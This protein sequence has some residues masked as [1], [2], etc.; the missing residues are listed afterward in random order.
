MPAPYPVVTAAVLEL[1][2]RLQA[3]PEPDGKYRLNY[4]E[5]EKAL[6]KEAWKKEPAFVA[7]EA[8]KAEQDA[9]KK[10]K[11][12][13]DALEV[14]P[15]IGEAIVP[16]A[17]KAGEADLDGVLSR[18]EKLQVGKEG[19]IKVKRTTTVEFV[20]REKKKT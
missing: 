17:K 9:A 12:A 16:V 11:K 10:A 18:L 5:I 20:E 3:P 6:L 2:K 4:S 14:K 8:E 19:E 13:A 15:G 1:V 7:Y